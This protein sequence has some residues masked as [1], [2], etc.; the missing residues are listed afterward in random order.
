MLRT[1][2]EKLKIINRNEELENSYNKKKN[3]FEKPRK[4]EEFFFFKR[5]NFFFLI[6]MYL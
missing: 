3:F 4:I 6:F 2:S 5:M 1:P